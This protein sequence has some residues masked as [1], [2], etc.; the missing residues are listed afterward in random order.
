MITGEYG[1]EGVRKR[2]FRGNGIRTEY[3]ERH[4]RDQ[5]LNPHSGQI[6]TTIPISPTSP[7]PQIEWEIVG[8]VGMLAMSKACRAASQ[9]RARKIDDQDGRRRRQ[10]RL[11]ALFMRS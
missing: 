11:T 9:D 10:A 5:I 1:N 8:M 4:L 7:R 2:G 6:A 3:W